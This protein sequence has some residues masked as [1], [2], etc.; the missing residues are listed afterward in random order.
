MTEALKGLMKK[1]EA[2][3]EAFERLG[4]DLS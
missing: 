2:P 3:K 4:I 1:N